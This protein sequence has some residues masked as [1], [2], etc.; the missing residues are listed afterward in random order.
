MVL[1]YCDF[2]FPYHE[3]PYKLE[4]QMEISR[5]SANV[6]AYTR[7]SKAAASVSETAWYDDAYRAR[8]ARQYAD[9][10]LLNPPTSGG[11]GEE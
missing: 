4:E 6:V 1:K 10:R 5:R 2:G 11:P 8:A 7:P 9:R 3:P